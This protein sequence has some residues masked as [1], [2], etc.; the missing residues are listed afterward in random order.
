MV[1]RIESLPLPAG[2]VGNGRRRRGEAS[3][4][5]GEVSEKSDGKRFK[6]PVDCIPK[7][8]TCLP[9]GA[10]ESGVQGVQDSA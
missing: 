7:A 5:E 9:A 4:G 2:S 6:V 10:L 8:H 1:G 3:R